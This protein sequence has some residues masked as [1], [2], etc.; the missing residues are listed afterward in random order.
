MCVCVS[1]SVVSDSATSWTV[2]QEA[3][4]SMG[5]SRQEHWKGLPFPSPGDHPYP[6]IEPEF[7]CVSHI[8]GR[9]STLSITREAPNPFLAPIILNIFTCLYIKKRGTL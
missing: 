2:A 7:D 4:P 9:L 5:F 6:A 8:A 1:H 3:P